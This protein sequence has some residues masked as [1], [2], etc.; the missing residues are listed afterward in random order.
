VAEDFS[1]YVDR[2]RQE[3]VHGNHI[4]MQAMSEM[5]NRSIQLYCYSTG[6]SHSLDNFSHILLSYSFIF[7]FFIEPINIFHTM[8]E[9]DN[10]PIR[11]SYQR[12]SHYNSIVDPYKAT[13][14]VGLGLPSYNPGAA[15]RALI[16]DAVRQS[17]ELHIEQVNIMH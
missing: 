9:S 6:A 11:L 1:T 15:D 3:Y 12:G 13:I 16:S 14:G 2:K 8:V 7:I 5:Y 17:E 10:E 4:E